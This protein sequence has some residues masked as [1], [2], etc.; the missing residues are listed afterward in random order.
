M[1]A[2]APA[3]SSSSTSRLVQTSESATYSTCEF[4]EWDDEVIRKVAL[5]EAAA[6]AAASSKQ[7]TSLNAPARTRSA[8]SGRGTNHQHHILKSSTS[9]SNAGG[10]PLTSSS[11]FG[12][13]NINYPN[14]NQTQRPQTGVQ[15]PAPSSAWKSHGRHQ[16]TTST[17][18][19]S[20]TCD[21]A[22]GGSSGFLS[23]SSCTP[24]QKT[25]FGLLSKTSSSTFLGSGFQGK[26]N[27]YASSQLGGTRA[28]QQSAASAVP[29]GSSTSRA[30]NNLFHLSSGGSP[31]VMSSEEDAAISGTASSSRGRAPISNT[32]AAFSFSG[33]DQIIIPRQPTVVAPFA[34]M[35]TSRTTGGTGTGFGRMA[36]FG[37]GGF[38]T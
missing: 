11:S 21:A 28:F 37:F 31:A 2:N 29:S 7:G 18:F 20:I 8:S 36:G 3:P 13:G 35:S 17:T 24:A 14:P 25:S 4:F 10:L 15:E 9:T 1:N 30:G 34:N 23:N 33:N 22:S 26:R 16:Q 32:N 12:F 38:G 27:L 19:S 6:S 5:E